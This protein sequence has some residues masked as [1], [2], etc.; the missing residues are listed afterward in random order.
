MLRVDPSQVWVKRTFRP[1]YAHTEATAKSQL[2]DP[3]WD[4]SIAIYPGMVMM[5]TVGEKC[6]LINGTGMPMGFAGLFVGG[7]SIDEPLR[8]G[9][10]GFAVWVLGSRAEAEVIAPAFD[11]GSAWSEPTD[12]TYTLV[13]AIVDGARRGQLAPAGQSGRGTLTTRPVARLVQVV[14]AKKIV[15]GGLTGTV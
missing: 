8:S 14:S 4:R 10:N 5:K 7:Y 12:G 2:L 3:A 13:H 9:F 15:I 1:T 11:E 6:T